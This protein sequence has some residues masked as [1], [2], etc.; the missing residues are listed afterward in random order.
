LRAVTGQSCNLLR[1]GAYLIR[2]APAAA[3]QSYGD[4]S[5]TVST[6]LRS[7]PDQLA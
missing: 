7:L 4:L 5:A 6:A 3:N 1:P 2:A